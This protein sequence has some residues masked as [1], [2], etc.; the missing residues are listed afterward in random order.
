MSTLHW[1]DAGRW[2]K[3]YTFSSSEVRARDV[4]HSVHA[5]KFAWIRQLLLMDEKRSES[6]EGTFF[7][8]HK[9]EKSVSQVWPPV[10][11]LSCFVPLEVFPLFWPK[12]APE[13]KTI[14]SGGWNGNHTGSTWF[15]DV[16]FQAFPP[17]VCRRWL[18]CCFFGPSYF[19]V[20]SGYRGSV[21][22]WSQRVRVVVERARF[23][24]NED[25][26]KGKFW[27]KQIFCCL[28]SIQVV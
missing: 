23:F 26:K 17:K 2:S 12:H 13:N 1:H 19:A 21:G 28:S 16:H 25:G 24:T 27:V 10:A 6:I 5:S 8:R 7:F 3:L 22:R 20:R 15:L 18:P 11:K 14:I 9:F 4:A